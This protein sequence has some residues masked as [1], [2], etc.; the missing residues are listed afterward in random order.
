MHQCVFESVF[1]LAL[2]H[3]HQQASLVGHILDMGLGSEA[4]QQQQ[5]EQQGLEQQQQQQQQQQQI[6]DQHQP[7]GQESRSVCVI[8]L[9][10]GKVSAM[11]KL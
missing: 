4:N 8:E 10:A 1:V 3:A 5:Q 9:G 2:Q 7:L 11:G 6:H